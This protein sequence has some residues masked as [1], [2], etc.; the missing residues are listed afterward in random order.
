MRVIG[1]AGELRGG[2]VLITSDGTQ[3]TIESV[4]QRGN[5]VHLTVVDLP[6][7]WLFGSDELVAF[8]EGE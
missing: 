6:F 7:P 5:G 4:E 1:R 2:D 3:W 8:R